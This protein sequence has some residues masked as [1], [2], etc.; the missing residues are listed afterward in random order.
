MRQDH[1]FKAVVVCAI[2]FRWLEG[3]LGKDAVILLSQARTMR[4]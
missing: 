3:P 1:R 2:S 4:F